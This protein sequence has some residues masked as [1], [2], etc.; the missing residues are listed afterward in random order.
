[1]G[2]SSNPFYDPD[3]LRRSRVWALGLRNPFRY[4]PH[5]LSVYLPPRGRLIT[6]S[7]FRF[8]CTT[9]GRSR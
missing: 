5:K 2:L 3:K 9:T 8:A 4:L 7:D 6:F 1:L